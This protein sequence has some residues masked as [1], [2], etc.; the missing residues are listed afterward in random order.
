MTVKCISCKPSIYL[1]FPLFR[2]LQVSGR[3]RK[4]SERATACMAFLCQQSEHGQNSRM[5][6]ILRPSC[7]VI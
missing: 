1:S 4:D 5:Q 7:K 6:N 2:L 3:E